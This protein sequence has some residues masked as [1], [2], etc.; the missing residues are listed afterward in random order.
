MPAICNP[1]LYVQVCSDFHLAG[2][3]PPLETRVPSPWS[4]DIAVSTQFGHSTLRKCIGSS[5]IFPVFF[6][7][8]RLPERKK[9]EENWFD[10]WMNPM[11]C[12]YIYLYMVAGEGRC[13]KSFLRLIHWFP[14]RYAQDKSSLVRGSSSWCYSVT[15]LPSMMDPFTRI[16]KVQL[17]NLCLTTDS[18]FVGSHTLTNWYFTCKAKS[19]REVCSHLNYRSILRVEDTIN[20]C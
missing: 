10:K 4:F 3:Q 12:K 2:L 13:P 5:P 1:M 9:T 20:P 11:D 8:V 7:N 16:Q 6:S 19:G 18:V 17:H 14:L 15:S